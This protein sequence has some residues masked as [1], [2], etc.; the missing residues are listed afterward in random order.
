MACQL[1]HH[2]A[3][4]DGVEVIGDGAPLIAQERRDGDGRRG[5]PRRPPGGMTAGGPARKPAIAAQWMQAWFRRRN[6]LFDQRSVPHPAV[7]SVRSVAPWN[8]EVLPA[9]TCSDPGFITWIPARSFQNALNI[10]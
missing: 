9:I 6:T 7:S 1:V 10:A 8:S 2:S 3:E 5:R 4:R